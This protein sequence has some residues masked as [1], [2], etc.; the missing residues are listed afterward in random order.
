MGFSRVRLYAS[1]ATYDELEG[2]FLLPVAFPLPDSFA[3]PAAFALPAKV[4]LLSLPVAC[5]GAISR[6]RE[7]KHGMK[8]IS[9][10]TRRKDSL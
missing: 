3:L 1:I 6:R 5:F 10:E 4:T 9:S 8:D 7:L 2:A